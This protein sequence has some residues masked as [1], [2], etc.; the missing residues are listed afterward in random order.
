MSEV[1]NINTYEGLFLFPQS[2]VG[3]FGTTVDHVKELLA[4]ADAQIMSLSKWEERK[5]AYDIDGN[6]RGLYFL[7]Y[8]KAPTD[9]LAGLDRDCNLSEKLLRAMITRA[10]HL[11][12]DQIHATDS[13]QELADEIKLRAEEKVAAESAA[14]SATKPAPAPAPAP[15]IETAPETESKTESKA[16]SK[17]ETKAES[18]ADNKTEKASDSEEIVEEVVEQ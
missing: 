15:E 9:K 8:F 4:R 18:K 1:I 16:E 6:K 17:A 2:A 5:L 11:T 13:Q 12:E 14:A 3:D 7:V 10:D